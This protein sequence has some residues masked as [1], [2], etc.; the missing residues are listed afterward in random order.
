MQIKNLLLSMI[1]T[2]FCLGAIAQEK[3]KIYIFRPSNIVN[4]L[5]PAR[6]KY[7]DNLLVK[8]KNN[9]YFVHEVEAGTHTYSWK[10]NGVKLK[11][12]SGKDY[13]V[14][15]D[16]TGGITTSP[17]SF[18]G[19]GGGGVVFHLSEQTEEKGKEY[20]KKCRKRLN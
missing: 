13:Y 1:L 11:V 19:Y 4:A 17:N 12:E 14:Q 7:N 5:V 10:K 6:V 18:N 9:T 16:Q 15:V 20:V 2:S 3:S 8:L